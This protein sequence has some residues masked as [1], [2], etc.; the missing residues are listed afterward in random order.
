MQKHEPKTCP[1]GDDIVSYMYD[2]MPTGGQLEFE[3][4]LAACEVCTDDF[5]AVSLA[6]FETYDWKRVEFDPLATPKI[7]I[8]YPQQTVTLGERISAWMGWATMVPVAAALLVCLGL[9]YVLVVVNTGTRPD[10][11]IAK[12]PKIDQQPKTITEAPAATA[13]LETGEIAS[14]ITKNVAQPAK[15]L[16]ASQKRR[17]EFPRST[18]AKRAAPSVRLGN[19]YAVN[20]SP[21]QLKPAPRLGMKDE[22]DDRSLRLADLFDE[23]NPPPQR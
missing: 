23:T 2:E 15:V 10:T 6:R 3:R 17:T 20:I 18:V 1:F 4:H 7:V 22:E 21:S 5:A 12:A 14:G 8:P 13:Q 19:D 9:G 11:T 16:P